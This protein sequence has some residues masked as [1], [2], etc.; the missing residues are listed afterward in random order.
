MNIKSLWCSF[1]FIFFTCYCASALKEC[2]VI[3]L[4]N[5]YEATNGIFVL[6]K[7]TSIVIKDTSLNSLAVYL[8]Q[9]IKSYNGIG[10]KI[11]NE[12]EGQAIF[13]EKSDGTSNIETY[14]IR[15]NKKL[16]VISA[17]TNEGLFDG[18]ISI[19][20][21]MRE[22][23]VK[24]SKTTINCWN[25]NDTAKYKWRGLMLDE[26]RHFFGKKTVKM[27]LDWMAF[28]KL[29]RFHWHLTDVP[30][31]RLQI[32][33][34]S[35][36]TSVGAIG[37]HSDSTAPAAYYTDAD[38][39]EIVQYAAAQYIT[40]IPEID[41][42]GHAT[43]A[44]RAYPEFSG[45]GTGKYANFTFNP[46][47]NKTYAYLAN[48]LRETEKLFPSKMI[49]LGGDEVSFGIESWK[50]DP[51]VQEL[52]KKQHLSN[53]KDV[54]LYFIQ[55]MAD[56]ALKMYNKVLL[57]DEA[58]DASLPVDST[59]ICWWRHDKPE[60]LHEAIEK[61][62]HIILCPRIPFY[63][64]FVQDSSHQ[65]GRKWQGNFSSLDK[66]YNFPHDEPYTVDIT[67]K[68]ILGIQA[69]LWTETVRTE[70]RLEYLV[71]PRI[72]ALSEAAWTNANNKN[73]EHFLI[74]LKKHL[75]WYQ[76]SG[77]YYYNPFYPEKTPEVID[78]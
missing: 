6:N 78:K 64:D 11:G 75:L 1:I 41:M 3:P 45:G 20:Q 25:I 18:I 58:A 53:V 42:P 69:D 39:E 77:I 8:Q 13:L 9:C 7:Y 10:L 4:P 50:N 68:L 27:L 66:V 47:N 22:A 74:R 16:I 73:Y 49:H 35:R 29:N 36:L 43:A 70:K 2:P 5:H 51:G 44:N 60:Q 40:V 23:G 65:Q 67:N 61:G 48:I 46:G 55:R 34:Y 71:F 17:P 57:W 31:W 24:K 21:L 72:T 28:Y 59:I 56:S 33:Q 38:I 30:G 19:L 15:M 26:S 54:E 32:K 63:F 52:M 37:N 12:D 62:Y 14:S 76:T